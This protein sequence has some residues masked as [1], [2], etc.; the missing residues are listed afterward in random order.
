MRVSSD[1]I[2]HRSRPPALRGIPAVT[3]VHRSVCP[4]VP[5]Q[6]ARTHR[7][8]PGGTAGAGW[9]GQPA[10]AELAGRAAAPGRRKA[11]CC[12]GVCRAQGAAQDTLNEGQST[13]LIE[14][15]WC[16]AA[17]GSGGFLRGVICT[18]GVVHTDARALQRGMFQ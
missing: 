8:A 16:R 12:S 4:S 14:G 18:H 5:A 11:P 1:T 3:P 9:F 17:R 2:S 10:V 7:S 6:H 13:P 15:P